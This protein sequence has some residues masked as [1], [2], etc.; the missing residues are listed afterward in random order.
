MKILISVNLIIILL[1]PR[2][3][4]QNSPVLDGLQ[5][6]ISQLI[7]FAKYSVV[8]VSA[9]SSHSY[10]IDKNYG[11][12][13]LFKNNR[14]EKKNNLW[15]VGSGIIYNQDGYIITR[16]SI[17]ADFEQI[18]VT[19]CDGTNYEAEYIGTD[20]RTGLAILK[21]EEKNVKPT[22]IG[23]SDEVLLHS[24][25]MVL[26]NSMGI[27]PFASFGLVNGYT[28]NGRLLLSAA[29]NPGNI[30]GAVFNLKGEIIGIVTAQVEAEI[31]F[32]GPNY[33]DYSQQSSIAIPINQVARTVDQVIKMHHQKINWLGIGLDT[34]SSNYNKL[35]IK[36]VIPGSPAARVG[37]NIGD[38]L[39]K[40]N[41]T[42]LSS[43]GILRKLIGATKPGT[44]VSINFIR[45]NRPL[46]VFPR[47]EQ[48]WPDG[49][50]PNKPRH[51]T[52]KLI[53]ESE[54]ASIQSPIIIS[55]ERFLQINSKMIQ[56][57]NE[58]RSLK[59]QINK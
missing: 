28:D 47:I 43:P 32:I 22:Q 30:G 26:G 59:S 4:S 24:L 38:R 20:E 9:K 3:F 55:P 52:H 54:R 57:E 12:L 58:I 6:E 18:K 8:T 13:S 19:L 25:V 50:N 15:T 14:E 48:I 21:I 34:D 53:N 31:S 44:S 27:S 33:L 5:A 39:V 56:M 2:L 45:H 40:Y 11:L 16:S 42:D 10:V 36:S 35:I 51:Y 29:I 1:V 49:F 17:L 46:K 7:H 37:L 41:E 23:N